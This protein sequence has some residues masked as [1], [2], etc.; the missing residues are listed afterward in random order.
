MKKTIFILVWFVLIGMYSCNTNSNSTS[1][2]INVKESITIGVILP[3][4]GKYSVIGEGEKMGIDLALDS[5]KRA[6]SDYEINIIYE[7]FKSETKD[8]ITA[9]NKLINIDKV[10]AIITSTTG[11]AEAVSPVIDG[12]GIPHFVI[13]PDLDILSRSDNNFRIYYNFISEA[14]VVKEFVNNTQPKSVNFFA[15]KYSSLQ[16]LIDMELEPEFIKNN[17]VVNGKEYVDVS[18]KDFKN[19]INKLKLNDADFWFLAPM[20]NQV[21]LYTNQLKDM[22]VLPDE[23][24]ILMGSF[25]FNWKPKDFISSLENYY[26]ATPAYEV[27]EKKNNFSILFQE[28]YNIS[29]SFDMAYAYDNVSILTKLLIEQ[30]KS[31]EGVKNG[32]NSIGTY[33]GASGIINFIGNN[34]TDA[35]IIISQVRNGEL[36]KVER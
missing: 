2:E 6:Y 33:N 26:I 14:N 10:N 13:S 7:D 4:T 36:V 23:N 20:T 19:V 1:N 18:E 11:A 35:E 34:E 12:R 3:L 17:I 32:F 15:S 28:R 9:A 25:T 29:P 5:L 31:L 8:A 30:N 16:K 27:S 21:D 22:G 24:R